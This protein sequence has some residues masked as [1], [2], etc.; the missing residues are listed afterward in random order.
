[1]DIIFAGG[2]FRAK[3]K[4]ANIAK[5]SS[6]RKI[7]VIYSTENILVKRFS[8]SYSP[9]AQ[10]WNL[11]MFGNSLVTIVSLHVVFSSRGSL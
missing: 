8:T 7:G 11:A 6:T 10:A 5:I 9:V 1:M 3:S 2:K 4:F